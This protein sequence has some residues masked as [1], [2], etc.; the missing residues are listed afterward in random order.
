MNEI[1]SNN[2][3]PLDYRGAPVSGALQYP[4]LLSTYEGRHIR[5]I[6]ASIDSVYSL[7]PNIHIGTVKLKTE[8]IVHGV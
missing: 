8:L 6:E 1:A 5:L 4:N 7:T 3:F 2:A